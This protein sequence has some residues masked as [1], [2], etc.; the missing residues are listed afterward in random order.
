MT[1]HAALEQW[2]RRFGWALGRLQP[3]ERED[4]LRETRSHI[5]ERV[6]AGSSVETVLAE[7]GPAERYARQFIDEMEAAEALGS[8]RTSDLARV[9]S[10]KAHQNLFAVASLLLLSMLALTG[11]VTLFLV[12][13]KIL[14]P[15][16]TGVWIGEGVVLI[17]VIDDPQTARD[18]LGLWLFPLAA[19]CLCSV[20]LLGRLLLSF[21]VSVLLAKQRRA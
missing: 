14:D 15:V 4:I 3:A 18:I 12:L 9:V 6:A 8:R 13:L 20:W 11:A 2:M 16:H 17:G 10:L 1:H 21:T 5:D 19:I 7:F